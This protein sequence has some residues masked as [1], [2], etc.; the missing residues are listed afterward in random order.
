MADYTIENLTH[1]KFSPTFN[2]LFDQNYIPTN[3]TH[4]TFGNDFNQ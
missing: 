1:V 2:E 3:T 4:L